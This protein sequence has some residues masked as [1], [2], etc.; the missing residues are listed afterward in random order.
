MYITNYIKAF[1]N[2]KIKC[3]KYV[4]ILGWQ[5]KRNVDKTHIN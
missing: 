3:T 2:N 4:V 1:K 5:K